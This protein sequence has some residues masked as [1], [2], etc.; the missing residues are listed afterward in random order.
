MLSIGYCYFSRTPLC[1]V[2]RP[3]NSLNPG[4]LT[5]YLHRVCGLM[6][7]ALL[8]IVT[9]LSFVLSLLAFGLGKQGQGLVIIIITVRS[10]VI[11]VTALYNN[12]YVDA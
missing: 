3:A 10:R 6:N 11:T 9:G 2:E 5:S 8:C 12:V 7:G 4:Y 1:Q